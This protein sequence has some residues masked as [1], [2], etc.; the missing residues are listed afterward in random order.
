M[1]RCNSGADSTV[2]MEE[3]EHTYDA[4]VSPW[5]MPGRFLCRLNV[6]AS[7]CEASPHHQNVRY[8]E[9]FRRWKRMSD[10]MNSCHEEYMRRA[11]RLAEKGRGF[12]NPNP[13]V[14]AVI[15]KDGRVIGEGWHTVYG[16]LHAEREAIKNLTESPDGA[17]IYVTLEPCCHTGKQPPCTEAIVESGIKRVFIGSYDPNPLVS[18]KG[19]AYL[20]EHG[21]TVTEG[22]CRE[23]CDR[24]NP[25]FFKYITKKMP[26]ITYKYAMSMDG[27][28]A[29]VSGDAK[30][31]SNE[32]SRD[33]VQDMR[34]EHM[35]IMAGIGTVLIDDPLLTVR[36]K[37]LRQ[38]VRIIL[39]SRLRIPM[40]SKLV[41][42]AGEFP[43]RIVMAEVTESADVSEI[44]EK[45]SQLEK[46]GIRV[47]EVPEKDG[48]LSLP[49]AMK[50]IAEEGID[51]IL[52]EGG[53]TL[54][55]NMMREG[56]VDEVRVFLA[57]KILGGKD[58]P[59]PVGGAG[60]L[61]PNNAFGFTPV[62]IERVGEDIYVR[63]MHVHRDN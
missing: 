12:V 7:K 48:H 38:P 30:W 11:I 26:Y 51:S 25:V 50:K 9:Q 44:K 33:M 4:F 54:A 62:G 27:K 59:S 24:L 53:G 43:L 18:G 16:S 55:W 6:R 14:G 22:V 63:Y 37:G 57:P 47:I 21:I 36:K 17:D 45:I 56:L 3:A 10:H 23:E 61:S 13:M 34:G 31:I 1:I 39:D 20:R 8:D 42:T 15:V 5:F 19:T 35:A 40:N 58:A 52:L 49:A 32:M 46:L 60:A 29:C 2:W 41:E 28:T